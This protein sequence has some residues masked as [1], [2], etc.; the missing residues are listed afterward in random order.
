MDY[1]NVYSLIDVFHT[2]FL[3]IHCFCIVF[4][5]YL[6]FY[7]EFDYFTPIILVGFLVLF[8]ICAIRYEVKNIKNENIFFII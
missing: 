8:A 5:F 2:F 3:I 7:S 4:C 6:S 1:K